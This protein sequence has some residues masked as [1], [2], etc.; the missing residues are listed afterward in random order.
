MKKKKRPKKIR[1]KKK[2]RL[3]RNMKKKRPKKNTKKKKRPKKNKKKKK[4]RITE[5]EINRWFDSENSSY[6]SAM[7]KGIGSEDLKKIK[8][9]LV[10]ASQNRLFNWCTTIEFLTVSVVK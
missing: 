7:E 8:N 10:S 4:R 3:K 5:T 6:G 1:S 2:K 9:L